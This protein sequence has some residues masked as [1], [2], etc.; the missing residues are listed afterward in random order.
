MP[1]SGFYKSTENR[2]PL[3]SLDHQSEAGRPYRVPP[4]MEYNQ[5]RSGSARIRIM[6]SLQQ[7]FQGSLGPLFSFQ[8][9]RYIDI[10][11]ES[12][13]ALSRIQSSM[14][15]ISAVPRPL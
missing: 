5:L 10:F 14:L 4:D 13:L 3:F 15:S 7:I 8:F 11:W 9:I 6:I 12:A 1:W 2:K